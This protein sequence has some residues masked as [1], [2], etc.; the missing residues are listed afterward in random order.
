MNGPAF[1]ALLRRILGT[2]LLGLVGAGGLAFGLDYAIFR[3]R[4]ATNH[5]AYGSVVVRHYYAVLEKNGKTT[6]LFDPPQDWP[7]VNTLFPHAGSMP[8]WYLKRHPEQR[9]DI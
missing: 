9:T 3:I 6:F 7:C 2:A 1:K 5:N 8:C 4:V